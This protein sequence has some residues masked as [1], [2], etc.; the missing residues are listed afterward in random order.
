MAL[1]IK[2][3][4]AVTRIG[5]GAL[6]WAQPE[7]AMRSF[8]IK[9]PSSAYV[10]RLFGVRDIALGLGLMSRNP[11]VRKATLRLGMLCDAFDCAAGAIETKDGKLTT[12][13]SAVLVG[14]A[15]AFVVL[16]A[17]ALR[18]GD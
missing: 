15:A 2:T 8:G 5:A 10:S 12:A 16:G 6:S 9:G 17:I 13:G 18:E 1:P 14:G 4:M 3:T 11:A 7:T